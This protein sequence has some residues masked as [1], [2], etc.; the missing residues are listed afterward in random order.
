MTWCCA[1]PIES[2]TGDN[3]KE[4]G[5]TQR[6]VLK[7]NPARYALQVVRFSQSEEI[8]RGDGH[9]FSELKDIDKPVVWVFPEVVV[10]LDCGT[11]EF[12]VP[13]AELRQL[14]KGDAAAAGY[15]RIDSYFSLRING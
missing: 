12:A 9:P 4:M 8:Q 3:S 10:C 2:N 13:E 6:R 11:A 14:A 5:S 15:P 1:K 7:E